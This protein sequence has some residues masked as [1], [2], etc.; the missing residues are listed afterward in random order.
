MKHV[1]RVLFW[2]LVGALINVALAWSLALWSPVEG[3]ASTRG[4]MPRTG[5]GI[6]TGIGGAQSGW[7]AL[8][9]ESENG[10]EQPFSRGISPPAFVPTIELPR[11]WIPLMPIPLAF[12]INTTFYA[13]IVPAGSLIAGSVRRWNRRARGRCPAC[14]YDLAGVDGPCPECGGAP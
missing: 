4:T 12:A 11:R 1:R 14:R 6:W 9:M 2:M 7:P 5:L 8:S 13:A 10:T 3:G